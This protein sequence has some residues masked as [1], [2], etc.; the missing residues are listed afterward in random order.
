MPVVDVPGLGEVEFPEGTPNDVME[1]AIKRTLLERQGGAT[2]SLL[3]PKSGPLGQSS[4]KKAP[5]QTGL[6]G[7]IAGGTLGAIGGAATP[8]PGGA[9]V[10]AGLGAA[11]G[12]AGE[13]FLRGEQPEP[14]DIGLS[15][16]TSAA[17]QAVAGPLIGLAKK[18]VAPFAGSLR[19]GAAKVGEMLATKGARL[20][21]A[22]ATESRIL[23]IADNITE[24]SLFGGGRMRTMKLGQQQAVESLA[25]D[26]GIKFGAGVDS[27]ALGDLT[28]DTINQGDLAFRATARSLFGAVDDLA[29]GFKPG[30]VA[31]STVS[32]IV[33]QSG[34]PIVH[35]TAAVSATGGVDFG[36]AK[37]FAKDILDKQIIKSKEGNRLLADIVKAPTQVDFKT[38]QVLRSDLLAVSRPLGE[39]TG[40]KAV[41]ISR[42]LS[43]MVDDAMEEA[44]KGLDPESF[45]EFRRANEFFKTGKE[46]FNNK[47]LRSLMTT[48]Q[49]QPEALVPRLLT[50][51]GISLLQKV[52]T[53]MPQETFRKVQASLMSEILDRAVT[54]EGDFVGKTL[55]RQL[56]RL[57]PK[58]LKEAFGDTVAADLDDFAKTAMLVQQ[59]SPTGIGNVAI[60]LTQV[61]AVMALP[62]QG[63]RGASSAILLGPAVMSHIMTNP[64]GIKLLTT[65]LTLPKGTEQF[66]KLVTRM[67]AV[68]AKEGLKPE[69]VNQDPFAGQTNVAP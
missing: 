62:V 33:D 30:K 59:K 63:L 66:T 64:T 60:Q 61:G 10:G 8:L 16:A 67:L 55:Q 9:I 26:F 38:A 43:K 45:A 7:E 46:V 21:P 6:F 51:R 40:E 41:Q 12:R 56:T 14:T 4:L 1:K 31:T 39:L 65:G 44:G 28:F 68:M 19:R 58:Y 42:R 22:Q 53:A 11:A 48:V 27:V 52:K 32:P 15:A 37:A 23:D 13:Q 50:P 3:E 34:K 29:K 57:G 25:E 35:A 5:P 2:T 49:Q 24:S 20:S 17:G 18:A 36:K 69:V 54:A 47:L